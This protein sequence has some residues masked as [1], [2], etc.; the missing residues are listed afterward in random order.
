M[1]HGFDLIYF[2]EILH[3]QSLLHCGFGVLVD[4]GFNCFVSWMGSLE[5]C[6]FVF[7][8]LF[9]TWYTEDSASLKNF[10]QHAR[11]ACNAA[12]AG[13]ASTYF[14]QW[15]RSKQIKHQPDDTRGNHKV[16]LF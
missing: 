13:G 14:N 10:A 3:L 2:F 6:L 7:G 1:Q 16:I 11:S 9:I 12:V 4:D 15:L 8:E 5:K